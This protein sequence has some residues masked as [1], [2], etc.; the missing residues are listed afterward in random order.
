MAN[1]SHRFFRNSQEGVARYKQIP[2]FPGIHGDD[3][4]A[5]IEV[6]YKF[7]RED[8]IRSIKQ[9][10]EG[11]EFRE[12]NRNPALNV[13]ANVELIEITFHNIFDS[14][15]IENRYREVFGLSPVCYTVFNTV[16]LFAII[17]KKQF[18]YFITQLQI[19][20]DTK[21]HFNP[22]YIHS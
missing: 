18:D 19:F 5:N 17:S 12:I 9:F 14:S 13:P 21:D 7:K 10:Y 20:I 3:E 1:K 4:E 2:R 22:R 16:G 6:N 8:Y 15:S 11:K